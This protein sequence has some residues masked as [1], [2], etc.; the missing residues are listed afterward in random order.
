MFSVYRCCGS[1]T[2][3]L[4]VCFLGFGNISYIVILMIETLKQTKKQT[5]LEN[6]F[7]SDH[8]S[9]LPIAD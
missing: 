7:L 2:D 9:R 8:R 4:V 6:K 5:E 1:A 3:D